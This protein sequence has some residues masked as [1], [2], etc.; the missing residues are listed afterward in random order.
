MLNPS[1]VPVTGNVCN[2]GTLPAS[3]ESFISL[4]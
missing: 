4:P 1:I 2:S 3:A